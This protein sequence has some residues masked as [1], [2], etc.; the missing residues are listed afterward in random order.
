MVMPY[1]PGIPI[2]MPA[3][4]TDRLSNTCWHCRNSTGSAPR[5]AH[6]IHGV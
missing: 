6:Y 2:L 1:R 5:F 4:R 3:K